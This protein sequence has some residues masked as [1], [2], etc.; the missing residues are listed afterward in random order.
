M[1]LF[2]DYSFRRGVS[3]GRI[4]RLL[5]PVIYLAA[6]AAFVADLMRSNTLAYGIIYIPVIGTGLLYRDGWMLWLLTGASLGL[7]VIGAFFPFQDPD[8]PDLVS[9]RVLSVLAIL[10]TALLVY[11]ARSIQSRLAAET[12]RAETAERI[13][14]DLLSSLGRE[15]RNPLHTMIAMT[16]LLLAGAR[17][18]QKG[19]LGKM[20][21]GGQYLLLTID[22]LIGLTQID[23]NPIHVARTDVG[24]LLRDAVAN[25]RSVAADSDVGM[26]VSRHVTA[27]QEAFDAYVDPQMTR[28]ILDNL[29][30]NAIRMTSHSGSIC[31]SIQQNPDAVQVAVADSAI[32]PAEPASSSQWRDPGAMVAALMTPKIGVGLTLS[33]RLAAAMGARLEVTRTPDAGTTVTLSLPLSPP[34][35]LACGSTAGT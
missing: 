4:A 28:R 16:S 35:Q 26:E 11:H 9:N 14:T 7:V 5:A 1:S 10:A 32:C 19:P 18:D 23:G 13:R 15:M 21:A 12:R 29:L 25:A 3:L 27:N 8:L 2:S 30:F 33:Y 17:A 31:V 6:A 34:H 24:V 22:N 20:R